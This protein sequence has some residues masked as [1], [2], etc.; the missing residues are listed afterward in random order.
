[1][2]EVLPG[3]GIES[4][5]VNAIDDTDLTLQIQTDDVASFPSSGTY[6]INVHEDA[7]DG[8]LEI[9]TVTGGQGTAVLTVTRASE[10][11]RGVQSANG[12]SSGAKIVPVLTRDGMLNPTFATLHVTGPTTMDNDLSVTGQFVLIPPAGRYPDYEPIAFDSNGAFDLFIFDPTRVNRS[13]YLILVDSGTHANAY[14]QMTFGRFKQNTGVL[15]DDLDW[16]TAPYVYGYM[17]D[18]T[19]AGT[20]IGIVDATGA[21]I[22][23]TNGLLLLGATATVVNGTLHV[24]GES[25]LEAA[26]TAPAFNATTPPVVTGSRT[27]GTALASLLTALAGLGLITDSSTP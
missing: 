25:T 21:Y 15:Q 19:R 20:S 26:I 24:V 13:P 27:D 23:L 18:A 1:V 9:M 7:N 22:D 2:T 3:N 12:W 11:F 16:D 17:A 8:P 6:R 10:S 4:T 5:L 14:A